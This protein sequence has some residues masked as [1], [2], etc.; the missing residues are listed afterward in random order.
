MN[1]VAEYMLQSSKYG[2]VNNNNMYNCFIDILSK[3]PPESRNEVLISIKIHIGVTFYNNLKFY[4]CKKLPKTDL[5]K[6][7]D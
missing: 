6:N 4:I 2:V 5:L 1:Y 7:F 3:I